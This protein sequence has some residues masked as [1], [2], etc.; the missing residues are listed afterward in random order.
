MEVAM[1]STI[2]RAVKGSVDQEHKAHS[3]H[4]GKV[5]KEEYLQPLGLSVYEL[6][7]ALKVPRSRANDIVLGRRAV[8]ANT[9]LR[10]GR[11]FGTTPEFWMQLQTNY[12]LD[13]E[14]R[15]QHQRIE[16]EIEP[17]TG[18]K[19][20]QKAPG[21]VSKP[22]PMRVQRRNDFDVIL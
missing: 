21:K 14:T 7:N 3:L 18:T 13:V 9:A 17:R 2:R 1:S 5:L 19:M 20:Q 4:P 11:Y 10:L 6:A 16:Q 12:D 22:K 15:N 8:T